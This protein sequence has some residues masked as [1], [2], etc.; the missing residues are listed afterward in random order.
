MVKTVTSKSK[1]QTKVRPEE[2]VDLSLTEAVV[3]PVDFI[4]QTRW[5]DFFDQSQQANKL[6]QAYL[7]TGQT[8]LGKAT[9]ARLLAR[10]L[11]CNQ[12]SK[13]TACQKC[14]SCLNWQQGWHPDIVE[15]SAAGGEGIEATR[16][17]MQKLNSRP[18]YNQY[19]V[20]LMLDIDQLTWPSLHALLK[21]FEEPP[22][23]TILIATATDLS[24]LPRTVKSRLQICRF[25]PLT[26]VALTKNLLARNIDL[27]AAREL[28]SLA[29][30]KP[31]LALSWLAAPEKFKLYKDEA[32]EFATAL[33]SDLVSQFSFSEGLSR[34]NQKSREE[35]EELMTHWLIILRDGLLVSLNRQ[36]QVY[37]QFLKESLQ[38]LAQT[39]GW[40]AA[41]IN[42]LLVSRRQLTNFANRRLALNSFFI[43]L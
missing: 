3:E 28:A 31:G 13:L 27:A 29:Q 42:Q 2:L 41:Q 4:G 19:R 38:A 15:L 21:T 32:T 16:L 24:R 34:V 26:G 33:K 30:G 8:A 11:V 14:E 12:P 37:H 43:N 1:R 35:M 10:A 40:W 25:A 7:I 9:F 6:A 18:L 17:F 22:P 20:G 23:A 39:S 5:L 36:E